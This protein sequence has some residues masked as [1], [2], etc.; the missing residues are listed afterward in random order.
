MRGWELLSNAAASFTS[1]GCVNKVHQIQIR[2]AHAESYSNEAVWDLYFNGFFYQTLQ[3][4]YR[5]YKVSGI[6]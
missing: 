4:C 3:F 2:S 5:C 6:R 1:E